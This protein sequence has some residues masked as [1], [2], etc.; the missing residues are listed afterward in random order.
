VR[1]FVVAACLLLAGTGCGGEPARAPFSP[2]D[3]GVR[4]HPDASA[5]DAAAAD[6]ELGA[7]VDQARCLEE[8]FECRASTYGAECADA[9]ERAQ[10]CYEFADRRCLAL[11]C[12]DPTCVGGCG[13]GECRLACDQA[14]DDGMNACTAKCEPRSEWPTA[15]TAECARVREEQI[16]ACDADPCAA[17]PAVLV[18]PRPP[19]LDAG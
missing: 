18:D 19:I 14:I 9:G 11:R 2:V 10:T 13:E 8:Y 15:C 16:A 7:D 12:A 17:L 4:A 3:G 1:F 6:A 5:P